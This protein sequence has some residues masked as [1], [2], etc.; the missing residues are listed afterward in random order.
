MSLIGEVENSQEHKPMEYR[1]YAKQ[2]AI[3]DDGKLIIYDI[4]KTIDKSIADKSTSRIEAIEDVIG[5]SSLNT[6]DQTLTGA[7]NEIRERATKAYHFKRTTTLA[8]LMTSAAVLEGSEEGDIYNISDNN[9]PVASEGEI[10][11]IKVGDNIVF[12]GNINTDYEN[13]EWFYDDVNKFIYI[14]GYEFDIL[15][16]VF[17][18]SAIEAEI[19]TKAAS[20]DVGALSD[21]LDIAESSLSRVYGD[22][23]ELAMLDTTQKGNIVNAINEVNAEVNTKA[24]EITIAA[25]TE[26]TSEIEMEHNT[27]IRYGEVTSLT[28]TLPET[29]PDDYISSVVFTSGETA[30]NMVYPETIKM[31]GEGCI[32]GVFVPAANKR[33]TVI[34][35]YDGVYV[36]GIV[37]GVG[38]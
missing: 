17:D 3:L 31:S 26:T 2:I 30:V 16:G 21:R 8:D 15:S 7:I 37:G 20:A 13:Q 27:E 19:G 28:L 33:Y 25:S 38:I 10:N 22:I 4:E 18:T 6:T 34:L 23:G 1:Y 5:N 24:D 32:D 35:S 9:N 29:L 36:S 14:F 11:P 12:T